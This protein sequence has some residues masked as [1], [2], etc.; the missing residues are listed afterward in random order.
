VETSHFTIYDKELEGG[1][2]IKYRNWDRDENGVIKI[3]EWPNNFIA[4]GHRLTGGAGKSK[5]KRCK[6]GTRRN[7]KTKRCRKNAKK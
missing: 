3:T 2:I 5:R 1:R 7:K 4:K 6:K